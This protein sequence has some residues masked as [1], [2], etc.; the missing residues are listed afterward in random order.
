MEQQT[1]WPLDILYEILNGIVDPMQ[2]YM[3]E[4]PIYICMQKKNSL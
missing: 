1:S 3:N 2:V 4:I